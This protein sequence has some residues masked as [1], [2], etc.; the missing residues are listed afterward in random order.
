MFRK[1]VR[2]SSFDVER[3]LSNMHASST[4]KC[5]CG[6]T[7]PKNY[8]PA[9]SCDLACTGEY[10]T[11]SM[12]QRQSHE[13]CLVSGVPDRKCGS[14]SAVAVYQTAPQVTYLKSINKLWN[15]T[16]GPLGY[17]GCYSEGWNGQLNLPTYQFYTSLMTTEVCLK[18]AQAQGYK[19]AGTVNGGSCYAANAVNWNNGGAYKRLDSDCSSKCLGSTQM[20]G[21]GGKMSLYDVPRSNVVYSTPAGV[22]G[23]VGTSPLT[24]ETLYTY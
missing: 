11:L 14:A 16:T 21:G 15:S 10:T 6:N 7:L 2:P 24:V 19:Y 8:L 1:A 22:T 13:R 12:F 18:L 5:I 3:Q 9:S 20:C 23:Y 17:L 4:D